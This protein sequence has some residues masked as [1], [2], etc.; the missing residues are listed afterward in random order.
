MSDYIEWQGLLMKQVLKVVIAGAV[1]AYFAQTSN[2]Q[3]VSESVSK[4]A[5]NASGRTVDLPPV[6]SLPSG[7]STA[8]GG[9]IQ[10]ID[11]VLDRFTL[12]VYGQRPM[13]IFFDER[14]QLFLDG[15]KIPLRE[16]QPSQRVSVETTLDGSAIFA[17]S[18]RL[19]SQ[20]T[21]GDYEGKVLAYH[22]ATGEL[23]VGSSADRIPLTLVVSSNTILVRKG[24][25]AFSSTQSGL[26]DLQR[27]S[28]VSITFASDN[29]GHAVANQIAVLATPGAH[30]I[31]GGNLTAIDIHS[32]LLS[33]V[34]PRDDQTYQAQFNS[35]SLPATQSL[36][37]GERVRV[38]VE[39]DGDHYQAREISAY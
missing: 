31:F 39:Y 6:P 38:E 12:H 33:L 28:L 18:I 23:T 21:S 25:D 13:K 29:R 8:L 19:L 35:T 17:L 37:V 30:F 9:E 14:T 10:D 2:A 7:K 20:S 3:A 24:Q 22:P 27:G 16:L 11:P 1:A 26:S 32:G 15:K 4:S 5:I 36:R 34:D